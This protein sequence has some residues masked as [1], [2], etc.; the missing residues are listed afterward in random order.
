[1]TP[2]TAIVIGAGFGGLALAIRLQSEGIATTL[3]EARDKPGGRAYVWQDQGHVFDAGP[4][5]I[6]DPEALRELWALSGQDMARDVTLMPVS[7]FYRLLWPDGKKFDYVN[8]AD[9]LEREIMAFSPSDLEGYRRFHD[10]AEEVYQEGYLKLGTVPFLKLGQM[11]RAAPA[12][13]RL[14]AYRSVHSIVARFIKDPHLRQAFSFHTLLVGGNPFSTS[15]IYALIHALERR[16]GVWFAKG[17][18]NA[19]VSGMVALFERLGGTLHLDTRVARIETEGARA[20][21]V[22]LSDGRKMQADMVAS[23]GDVMHNYRDLLGHTGRGRMKAALLGKQRWSMSL[24]VLHFGLSKMPEGLA[25]HTILF[26]PRY[27]E[28]VTEIFGGP[29][30]P[31]DFSLYLHSPC[32]TDPGLAPPGMST[33]YVLAPVPHLGRADIDWAAEGPR[34]ADRIFQSLEERLIPDLRKNLTVQRI[35]SPTDFATELGAH[36]GSAF[37]IEP[38]LRQSAWFRPH[39]RDRSIRNFYIVGAGTHPGAGIPGVVGSAKATAGVMIA[40]ARA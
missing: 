8:D 9:A 33:H 20:T 28:L 1:M 36:H 13:V 31:E 35:F 26:G 29:K 32:V 16:G 39:N 11:M 34:L 23:N 14:E 38:I 22:T 30:L 5:V 24:F 25:H 18:T 27:R 4:T 7:P 17:G 10:Y 12:L 37:S 6:T 3:L 21:G 2:R 19:L 15:S 40:D